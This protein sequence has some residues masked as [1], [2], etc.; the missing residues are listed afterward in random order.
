MLNAAP[1]RRQVRLALQ[2]VRISKYTSPMPRRPVTA[3]RR[4]AMGGLAKGLQ[5][6][7]KVDVEFEA[8]GMSATI[9]RIAVAK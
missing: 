3:P 1:V 6:G 5:V 4:E 8:Q 9:T 2:L 7:Q